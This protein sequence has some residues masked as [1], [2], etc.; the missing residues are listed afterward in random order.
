MEHWC[1]EIF[2]LYTVHV[3]MIAGITTVVDLSALTLY[4]TPYDN[5]GIYVRYVLVC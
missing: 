3:T 4:D 5:S 2:R 1:T